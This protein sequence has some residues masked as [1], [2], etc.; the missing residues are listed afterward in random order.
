MIGDSIRC[1]RDGPR[2][3]G[4]MGHHLDRKG[5]V[6]ITDLSQFAKLIADANRH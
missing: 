2:A 4:I 5:G 1:D 3:V 6:R